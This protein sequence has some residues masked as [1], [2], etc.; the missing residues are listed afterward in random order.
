MVIDGNDDR[1][2]DL[3]IMTKPSFNIKSVGTHVD[4]VDQEGQIFSRDCAEYTIS[5]PSGNTLQTLF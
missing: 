3:G 2:I 1:G 5:T 4:D